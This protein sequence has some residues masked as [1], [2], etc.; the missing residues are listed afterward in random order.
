MGL[1]F[2]RDGGRLLNMILGPTREERGA[3]DRTR[4]SSQWCGSTP[5]DAPPPAPFG[6]RRRAPRPTPRGLDLRDFQ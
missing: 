2:G 1:L 6:M 3:A 4:R 5:G